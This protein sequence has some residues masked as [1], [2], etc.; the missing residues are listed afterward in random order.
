MSLMKDENLRNLWLNICESVN[1]L[2]EI[3][4]DSKKVMKPA[5]NGM[6]PLIESFF[7]MYKILCDDEMIEKIKQ[8]YK[9]TKSKNKKKI[10]SLKRTITKEEIESDLLNLTFAELRSTELGIDELLLIMCEKNRKVLNTMI[11]GNVGLLME[12][13]SVLPKVRNRVFWV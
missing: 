11:R 12:S 13:L 6:K 1:Y 3:F 7:I 10:A 8:I 2:E 9:N 5:I 4:R